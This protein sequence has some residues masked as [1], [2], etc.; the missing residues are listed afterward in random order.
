MSIEQ[1]LDNIIINAVNVTL[2]EQVGRIVKTPYDE[3][4]SSYYY[5]V[6][7]VN[8]SVLPVKLVCRSGKLLYFHSESKR[9]RRLRI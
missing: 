6:I 8:E 5:S 1:V 3:V 2:K 7:L 9:W 4:T